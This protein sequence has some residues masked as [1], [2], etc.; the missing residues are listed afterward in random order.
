M[1]D[2]RIETRVMTSAGELSFEEYF[3][4]RQYQDPV[5]SVRFCGS[6]EADLRRIIEA[7]R[8]RNSCCSRPAIPYE[9]WRSLPCREFVRRCVTRVLSPPP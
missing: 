6:S 2:S 8:S 9:H 4:Q 1:S 5:Q 3:V 7:I